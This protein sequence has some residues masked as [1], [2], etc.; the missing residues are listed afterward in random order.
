MSSGADA[1]RLEATIRQ[2]HKEVLEN[3]RILED[4]EAR[5][6]SNSEI[7]ALESQVA[8][9]RSRLSAL[10]SANS[11]YHAQLSQLHRT[12]DAIRQQTA[13]LLALTEHFSRLIPNG[14][15]PEL[16][17]DVQSGV[18]RKADE[19]VDTICHEFAAFDE[20]E[21]SAFLREI[22][23]L[24]TAIDDEMDVLSQ[25]ACD[26]WDPPDDLQ[27]SLEEFCA[28]YPI[29]PAT[30]T[31]SAVDVPQAAQPLEVFERRFE[32]DLP[33]PPNVPRFSSELSDLDSLLT[34]Q[35]R[36]EQ[37]IYD[38]Q[39]RFLQQL[40]DAT[41]RRPDAPEDDP[42]DL[43][44]DVCQVAPL[45]I[46]A[47][48]PTGDADPVA[49]LCGEFGELVA[50]LRE[51][52]ESLRLV[53]EFEDRVSGALSIPEFCPPARPKVVRNPVPSRELAEL[54]G[55]VAR[56]RDGASRAIPGGA[57]Q[58]LVQSHRL[59][60]SV[61]PGEPP[62]VPRIALPPLFEVSDG[63]I[64]EALSDFLAAAA[65]KLPPALARR[66][67]GAHPVPRIEDDEVD[68][69]GGDDDASA[70]A[71]FECGLEE[72]ASALN[73][74][75]RSMASVRDTPLP[76]VVEPPRIQL[77]P[78]NPDPVPL[79]DAVE[80]LLASK[81]QSAA[82]L[83]DEIADLDSHLA[84]TRRRIASFR[85]EEDV[86]DNEQRRL[87]EEIAAIDHKM[88]ALTALLLDEAKETKRVITE[89]DET[90]ERVKQLRQELQDAGDVDEE[91][92]RKRKELAA[93]RDKYVGTKA[94]FDEEQSLLDQL[95]AGAQGEE[96]E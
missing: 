56:V 21:F 69:D 67:E 26:D 42:M 27:S 9:L 39:L 13:E 43:V 55:Q 59:A 95:R 8:A 36:R 18:L 70:E 54:A 71:P 24:Q 47:R 29:R 25:I 51:N 83:N 4:K 22:H 11:T 15:A 31:L 1:A 3:R 46:P 84:A 77:T 30:S 17:P 85:E 23:R 86:D 44:G 32:V 89:K 78:D 28:R 6:P 63:Q 72:R 80:E 57:M 93:A 74:I 14:D 20:S 87:G 92:D 68:D 37:K 66:F 79:L 76:T 34:N 33:T 45:S 52:C 41:S 82:A 81:Q 94:K 88:A 64:D 90:S 73:V 16:A 40:K 58:S 38:E 2:I 10:E 62:S 96:G 19:V 75:L 5:V 35:R 12:R 60:V 48:R 53:D 7:S 50:A 91:L 49:A 65:A 61:P